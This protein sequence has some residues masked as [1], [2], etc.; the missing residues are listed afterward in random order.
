MIAVEIPKLQ[1]FATLAETM[2]RAEELIVELSKK[3]EEVV[4]SAIYED[5]LTK[6]KSRMIK[7]LGVSSQASREANSVAPGGKWC[8]H[9]EMVGGGRHRFMAWYSRYLI[10]A[11]AMFQCE[12]GFVAIGVDFESINAYYRTCQGFN[13]LG[14]G[15]I[16][17]LFSE[18]SDLQLYEE[19]YDAS[20]KIRP[21][22]LPFDEAYQPAFCFVAYQRPDLFHEAIMKCR[23]TKEGYLADWRVKHLSKVSEM[24]GRP[25]PG[26]VTIRTQGA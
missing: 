24:I 18:E 20:M 26:F 13:Y 19:I 17:G 5:F 16:E 8:L 2:A 9:H 23:G 4:A 22:S 11:W 15:D 12:D 3:G 21:P 14:Q 10:Y 25:V 7:V 1:S 6:P